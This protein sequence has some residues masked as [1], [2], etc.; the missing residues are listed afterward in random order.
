MIKSTLLELLKT[1]NKEEL[2]RFEDF[3]RSPY[4]NKNSNV[5]KLFNV[6][7]KYF[8]DLVSNN[9]NR[10]SVWDELFREKSFNYGVMK[11]L[12]FE[13]QKLSEKFLQLQNYEENKFEQE[14]NL[15]RIF[16]NRN[17]FQLFEKNL[18]LFKTAVNN[19]PIDPDHFYYK[20]LSED[21]EQTYL[22]IHYKT[23]DRNFCRSEIMNESLMAFFYSNFFEKNYNSFHDSKLYN[24]S[25]DKRT[26]DIVLK[27]FENNPVS[28]NEF[29]LMH[30]YAIKTVINFDDDSSY[31]KLKKL[32]NKLFT[33]LNTDKKFNFSMA[34]VNFCNFKIMKGNTRYVKEL[35][36]T[37]KMMVEHGFYNTGKDDYISPPMYA[38]I[39]SMAGNLK[40]FDWA[41]KF[42]TDFKDRLH[43]SSGEQYYLLANVI[44]N[45]KKKNYEDALQYL[46][47]FKSKNEIEKITLKRFQI[48]IYYESGFFDELYSLIDT[49]KHF[50]SY[51]IKVTETAKNVFANFLFFVQKLAE[52]KS[53]IKDGKRNEIS[54]HNLKDEIMKREVSNK[55][56][57]LEKI[58]EI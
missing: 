51:D 37:Y 27:S 15:L 25:Y 6:I 18:K 46:T 3:L 5:I 11:N 1:F 48:M 45:I 10:E 41:E 2:K 17:L 42:I 43:P 38:N 33:K 8:P 30:Y 7:K 32:L 49:S 54:L 50:I 34:L 53:G 35:F 9:L 21:L 28:N 29:V 31:L 44:L 4:Y 58:D 14:L 19:S 52:L 16:N 57:L 13:L 24:K 20:Y 26:L 12:I 22:S 40:K 39:V 55:I 23:K 36:D 56:W 47:K